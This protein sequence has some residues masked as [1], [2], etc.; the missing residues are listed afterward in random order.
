M[1]NTQLL[2][3]LV[4]PRWGAGI[5]LDHREVSHEESSRYQTLD[6]RFGNGGADTLTG[7]AG[8]DLLDGGSDNDMLD[9]GE[10]TDTAVFS[11]PS[12]DYSVTSQEEVVTVKDKTAKRDGENALRNIERLQFTDTILTIEDKS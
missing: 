6:E 8:A 12:A 5:R 10:G 4:A 3:T 7:G 11:G 9:G 2:G 1:I